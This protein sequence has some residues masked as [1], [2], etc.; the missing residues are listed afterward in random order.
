MQQADRVARAETSRVQDGRSA[1]LEQAEPELVREEGDPTRLRRDNR[2]DHRDVLQA[3][4]PSSGVRY[5][6]AYLPRGVPAGCRANQ[7]VG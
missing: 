2:P 6:R 4:D 1:L 7:I 5:G 3:T